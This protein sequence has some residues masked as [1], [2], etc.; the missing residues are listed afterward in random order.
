MVGVAAQ[1][2]AQSIT[3]DGIALGPQRIAQ[4]QRH[5]AQPAR[6][7]DAA[8]RAALGVVQEFG[9]G[10]GEQAHQ[11]KVAPDRAAVEIRQVAAL[12]EFVP[13]ADQLAVVATVDAV[14]D[15]RA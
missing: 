7:A 10:P 1:G 3:C 5:I 14:G 2:R 8:D 6:M 9:L 15:Q 13:G 4:R 11:A 12:C